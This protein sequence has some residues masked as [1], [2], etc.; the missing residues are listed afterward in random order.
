MIAVKNSADSRAGVTCPVRV[1]VQIQPQ[2]CS[3]ADI[4]RAVAHY[5]ELGVD[6]LF[7]WDH[8]FPMYGPREGEHY[9]CWSMLGAW[10]EATTHVEF[11]PLVTC[12]SYRN[13]D[14]LADMARTIDHI[15][16]GRL[17][18]G[19]GSGWHERDFLE[20][21]YEFGT[22]AS[23]LDDLGESLPRIQRRLAVLNP[24]PK[25]R[26]PILIGGNGVRRTLRLAA[27]YADIWHGFGTPEELAVKHRLL[28]DWCVEVGRDPSEIER[29]AR[30]FRKTPD[31]V[32]RDLVKA[33]TTLIQ[34][35]VQGP[36]FDDHHVRDWLAFRDDMNGASRGPGVA[37]AED[38]PA[39]CVST[40]ISSRKE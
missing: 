10:A 5:E 15:S 40:L 7:N 29:S 33:G 16:D 20:Y 36:A 3:Y 6:I 21:G 19:I 25:R 22:A 31:E 34:L 30:V 32:G 9:E 12:N 11:G 35:V 8:F 2:H 17:I 26:I 24:L 14:L 13:P 18:L 39:P 37:G 38:G 1:G 28:D 27:V 23:R 4:R